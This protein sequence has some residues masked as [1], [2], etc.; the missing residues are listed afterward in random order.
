MHFLILLLKTV[1]ELTSLISLDILF[2][3]LVAI[4]A[5]DSIPKC[6]EWMFD[7]ERQLPHL[8][9]SRELFEKWKLSFMISGE[10]FISIKN[11]YC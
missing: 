7:I 6:V 5:M 8:N 1:G 4:F 3:I 11:L 9:S 10:I 2:P